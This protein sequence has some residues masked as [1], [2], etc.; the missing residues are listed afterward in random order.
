MQR[1]LSGP[2]P[3]LKAPP[4]TFD[5]H[6]HCYLNRFPRQV[7]RAAY[8]PEATVAHYRELTRWLGIERTLVV[9]PNAYGFDNR[10]TLA[11]TA[12]L[13]LDRA[14][15]VVVVPSDVPDVELERL[16]R[17]GAR[18][19]RFMTLPGGSLGWTDLERLAPRAHALGW[20]SAVQLDGRDLPAREA[21]LKQ[22]PGPYVIDHIGKFLEPVA[23]DHESFKTLLRLVERGNCYVKLAAPYETSKTGAPAFSD[24]AALAKALIKAAPDRMLWATNWPHPTPPSGYSPNDADLLDLLLDWAPNAADRRKILADNP[25]RLLGF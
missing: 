15:A 14:R 22:I 6:I 9:Q 13:G 1:M 25:A 11:C 8:P 23:T 10:C 7:E 20:H 18:G 17:A 16:D 21:A 24:V 5:T 19:V 3:R 12:E 4:G 2:P